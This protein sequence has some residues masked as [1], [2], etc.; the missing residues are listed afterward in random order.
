[1]EDYLKALNKEDLLKLSARVIS[2]VIDEIDG[3]NQ[4][5]LA[6]EL[7]VSTATINVMANANIDNCTASARFLRKTLDKL[8]IR[9]KVEIDIPTKHPIS[10]EKPKEDKTNDKEE[11]FFTQSHGNKWRVMIH[12]NQW[13]KVKERVVLRYLIIHPNDDVDFLVGSNKHDDYKGSVRVTMGGKQAVFE[14]AT[15]NKA[16]KEVYIRFA[17]GNSLARPS[18]IEGFLIHSH[19]D[20]NSM[21]GYTVIAQNI[22]GTTESITPREMPFSQFKKYNSVVADFFRLRSTAIHCHSGIF[23]L[24]DLKFVVETEKKL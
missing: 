19:I 4:K 15:K 23:S 2:F 20:D 8:L 6:K 16:V 5:V 18:Y 24:D 14:L 1:M 10:L 17:I 13:G 12:I 22:S 3:C 11:S 7:D 9:Y 21:S